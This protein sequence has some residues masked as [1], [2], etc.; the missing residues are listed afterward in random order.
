MVPPRPR[1]SLSLA[2][3]IGVAAAPRRYRRRIPLCL[4]QRQP[5]RHGRSRAP[6]LLRRKRVVL[7]H[8]SRR[9]HVLGSQRR[10]PRPPP[11][12][13]PLGSARSCPVPRRRPRSLSRHRPSPLLQHQQPL[14]ARFRPPRRTGEKRRRAPAAPDQEHQNC[15][16]TQG[17][18]AT[19][20]P[21]R[22][23][24][25]CRHRMLRRLRG[26]LGATHPLRAGQ[27]HRRPPCPA[28]RRLCGH[29]RP[30]P[31]VGRGAPRPPARSLAR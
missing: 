17:V 19:R 10:T 12:R 29:G 8:G 21:T 25:G 18:L 2:A 26:H 27:S 7:P 9:A 20:A 6:R 23:R 16:P 14:V 28:L 3:R 5:R 1:G 24:H 11:Q 13:R 22:K 31:G 30:T 4:Q 15:R